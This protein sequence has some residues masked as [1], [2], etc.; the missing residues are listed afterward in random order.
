MPRTA[1]TIGTETQTIAA[2]NMIAAHQGRPCPTRD[3]IAAWTGVPH[4]AIGRLLALLQATGVVEIEERGKSPKLR[5]IRQVG[6][7][8]TGWSKRDTSRATAN[9][10]E[11]HAG[12]E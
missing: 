8:W 1:R 6:K 10:W 7:P 9:R 5:R 3:D 2:L 12:A 11:N 4:R